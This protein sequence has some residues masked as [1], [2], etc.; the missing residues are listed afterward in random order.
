MKTAVMQPAKL[1]IVAIERRQSSA[2]SNSPWK[3]RILSSSGIAFISDP[4]Q[5]H[6]QTVAPSIASHATIA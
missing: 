4:L 3:N 2:V 6:D 1:S 5:R